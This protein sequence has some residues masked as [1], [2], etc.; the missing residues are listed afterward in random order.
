MSGLEVV[1]TYL[2]SNS[3]RTLTHRAEAKR[4]TRDVAGQTQSVE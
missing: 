4:V 2:H 3:H 1:L